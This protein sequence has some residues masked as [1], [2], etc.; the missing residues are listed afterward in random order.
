MSINLEGKSQIVG[1]V[2]TSMLTWYKSR[3]PEAAI[4]ITIVSNY[5]P[6]DKEF[7]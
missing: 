1:K 2:P 4:M 6:T 5:L 7:L 3:L